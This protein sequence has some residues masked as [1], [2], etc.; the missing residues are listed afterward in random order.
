MCSH[1]IQVADNRQPFFMPEFFTYILY[2]QKLGKYYI[3]STND[4][5]RRLA[6]HNRGKTAYAKIGMPWQLKYFEVFE[7]KVL[8]VRREN[9]LKKRK[10]RKYLEKLIS[11]G[12]EHPG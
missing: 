5:K 12:S 11:A 9:E 8:A 7:S 10:D 1:K 3:G 2:S 4:L 6:D